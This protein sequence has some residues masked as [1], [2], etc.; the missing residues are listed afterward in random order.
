[1]IYT[2][3]YRTETGERATI[4]I[5]AENREELFVKL[6][7]RGIR[8]ITVD[9]GGKTAIRWSWVAVRRKV[10]VALTTAVAAIGAWMLIHQFADNEIPLKESTVNWSATGRKP[11]KE[12]AQSAIINIAQPS[13]NMLS[14]ET[15]PIATK[16]KTY[17]DERGILR[18]EGGLRV[19]GQRPVANPIQLGTHQPR[20]FKH[21]AEEQI[22]WLLD[23]KIGEPII[24]DYTYGEKFRES[25]MASL[26]EPVEIL[27]TDDERTR[28]L[29]MAVQETKEDLRKRMKSGDDVVRIMNETMDEYRQLARY[30]HELQVQLSEIRAD[31]EQ[32]SDQDVQDFTSAANELLKHYGLPPLV[33]PRAVIR[34]LRE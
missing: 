17:R 19:P 6:A 12:T 1:M 23:M 20:L 28:E 9:K 32:Y 22:S 4:T 24:G 10:M 27:E 33:F 11:V 21:D 3:T 13:N 30:K 5:D 7:E 18:Y 26:D 16:L 8:A 34:G 25:F 31:Q 14:A 2:I 15:K 29:K